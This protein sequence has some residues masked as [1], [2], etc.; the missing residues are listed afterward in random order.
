MYVYLFKGGFDIQ[1]N[2]KKKRKHWEKYKNVT[3]C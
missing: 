2:K 3:G 1:F